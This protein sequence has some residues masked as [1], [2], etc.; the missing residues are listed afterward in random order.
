[1]SEKD[2]VFIMK[3]AP[4]INVSPPIFFF[5][6]IVVCCLE[7]LG[8]L[9]YRWINISPVVL[10]GIVRIIETI[11]IYSY[12]YHV[13]GHWQSIGW[14]NHDIISRIYNG[15][16]WSLFFGI[17]VFPLFIFSEL[18]LNIHFFQMIRMPLP[19]SIFDQ[20]TYFI[21]GCIIGPFTEEIVFRGV[22]YGY[23]R[24]WGIFFYYP[25]WGIAFACCISTIIFVILHHQASF[26]P[27][28]QIIGGILFVLSYEYTKRIVT[29]IT[30]HIIG[31]TMILLLSYFPV[32]L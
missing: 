27:F 22:V 10:T 32:N 25:K 23:F 26:V 4:S 14:N 6:I 1:V 2:S 29:P 31:N 18:I 7:L 3:E 8:G 13:D 15:C 30:I 5:T 19:E 28:T 12:I 17:I 9:I 24:K 21:V 20:I 11:A 16:Q